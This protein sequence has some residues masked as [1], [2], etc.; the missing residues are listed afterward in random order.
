MGPLISLP[1]APAAERR[2]RGA[3]AAIMAAP[4]PAAVL[5]AVRA[6]MRGLRPPSHHD[7]V[8]KDECMYSFDSPESP[9]GLFVNLRSYQV[10]CAC[11]AGASPGS[12]SGCRP[13]GDDCATAAARAPPTHH[14]ALAPTMWSWTTSAAATRCTCTC[15]GSG[16]AGGGCRAASRR[17]RRRARLAPRRRGSPTPPPAAACCRP[18][19]PPTRT[20][21]RTH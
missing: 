15:S 13:R 19:C 10:R 16:C 9:G 6:G 7:K 20:H 17:R 18:Q 11:A 12:C 14:R 3:A 4:P 1:R 2:Q 5:D 21:A 8:Y